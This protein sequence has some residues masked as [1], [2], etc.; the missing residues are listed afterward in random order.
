[1][2]ISG[3]AEAHLFNLSLKKILAMICLLNI[4]SLAWA[5]TILKELSMTLKTYSKN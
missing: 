4:L 1:L 2:I 3:I 5:Y